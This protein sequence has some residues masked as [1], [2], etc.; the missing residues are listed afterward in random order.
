MNMALNRMQFMNSYVD[1]V[2]KQEAIA[3]KTR[4]EVIAAKTRQKAIV[5][6]AK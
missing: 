2:T 3:T 6:M 1:N 4:Q 5:W